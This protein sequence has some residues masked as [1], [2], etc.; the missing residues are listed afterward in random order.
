MVTDCGEEHLVALLSSLL[1]M[2]QVI[3]HDRK[4]DRRIAEKS[5]CTRNEQHM[6]H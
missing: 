1:H 2:R 5:R 4:G 3:T 6:D